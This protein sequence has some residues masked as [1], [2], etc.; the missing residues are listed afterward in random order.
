MSD[1]VSPRF[2][3]ETM[4]EPQRGPMLNQV[5]A[6]NMPPDDAGQPTPEERAILLG[7][8]VCK[9]PNN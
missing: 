5:Y 2:S 6:C 9:A 1:G 7:W 8:F 3:R 4:Y